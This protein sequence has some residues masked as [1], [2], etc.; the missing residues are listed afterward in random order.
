MNFNQFKNLRINFL[1]QHQMSDHVVMHGTRNIVLSAPHGVSQ[2]RLGKTKVAEIGTIPFALELQKRCNTFLIA[3]TKNNFDD[4]NFDESCEFK[5]TLNEIIETHKIKYL[6]DIHGLAS[7]R[8]MDVNLGINFG[9]SINTNPTLF[10]KLA[11]MLKSAGFALSID[12][13]FSG[14]PKTVAGSMHEKHGIFAIQVEIN[15]RLTNKPENIKKLNAL[16]DVFEK[17]I[18][19]LNDNLL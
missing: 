12:Q 1:N 14:G 17:F 8:P 5:T 6:F 11:Q 13:P 3:K 9:Q 16:I 4:A 18:N 10:D 2:V 7:K 15:S 19:Q